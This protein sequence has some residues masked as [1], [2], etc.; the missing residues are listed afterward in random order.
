[1]KVIPSV[2]VLILLCV[3]FQKFLA[4][5][6]TKKDVN[7]LETIEFIESLLKDAMANETSILHGLEADKIAGFFPSEDEDEKLKESIESIRKSCG[8]LCDLSITGK[9]GKFYDSL[10][11]KVWHVVKLPTYS[12]IC[13]F[14]KRF[15]STHQVNCPA[16]FSNP[17]IDSPGH[18]AHPP[19]LPPAWL[20]EEYTYNGRVEMVSKYMDNIVTKPKTSTLWSLKAVEDLIDRLSYYLH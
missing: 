6:K 8:E 20:L 4:R 15:L 10:Q 19:R 3:I 16:L 18:F 13:L 14:V 5:M 9:P 1:M 11:K 2:I 12:Y 17:Y 7:R